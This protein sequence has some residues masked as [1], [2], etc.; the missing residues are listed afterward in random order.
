MLV[1]SD[2]DFV[3]HCEEVTRG[4][5]D[6]GPC[7]RLAGRG[8]RSFLFDKVKVPLSKFVDNVHAMSNVSKFVGN[9]HTTSNFRLNK[10]F[11]IVST[12]RNQLQYIPVLLFYKIVNKHV[13]CEFD[14]E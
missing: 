2:V 12:N 3:R 8:H 6:A 10:S 13:S 1:C 7:S 11:H 14:R 9:M 4:T 5:L